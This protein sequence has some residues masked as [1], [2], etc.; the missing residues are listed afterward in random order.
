VENKVEEKGF[1]EIE[2]VRVDGVFKVLL[3]SLIHGR[4]HTASGGFWLIL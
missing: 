4:I 3:P 2:I 1:S